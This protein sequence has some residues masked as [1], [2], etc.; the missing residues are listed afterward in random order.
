M[1]GRNESSA[2]WMMRF[3]SSGQWPAAPNTVNLYAAYYKK[4]A[5]QNLIGDGW[6]SS[7]ISV[8]DSLCFPPLPPL[9]HRP[10]F[11]LSLPS[12]VVQPLTNDDD[13]ES[14]RPGPPEPSR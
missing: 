11:K 6:P 13:I 9:F 7:D 14:K 4:D 12:S 5:T 8:I 3:G 10:L 2:F 1:S